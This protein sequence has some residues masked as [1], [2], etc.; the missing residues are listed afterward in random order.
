MPIGTGYGYSTATYAMAPANLPPTRTVS[1]G[2]LGPI[3][4]MT[5][6]IAYYGL[7]Y[8]DGFIGNEAGSGGSGPLHAG[9]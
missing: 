9:Y 4:D 8:T 2:I 7:G 6:S 3:P 5:D 1:A